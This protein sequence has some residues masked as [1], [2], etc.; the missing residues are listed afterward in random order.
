[1]KSDVD[2]RGW[3]K[4][5]S[6]GLSVTVFL[7]LHS[8]A[9]CQAEAGG[10]LGGD[11]LGGIITDQT[12]TR[13][14][15]DFYSGFSQAWQAPEGLDDVNLTVRERPSARWGSLVWV[16]YRNETVFRTFIF[17]GRSDPEALGSD[18]A[19]QVAERIARYRM[20]QLMFTDPDL[21]PGELWEGR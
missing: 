17:P 12:I 6:Q 14:G 9:D 19:R 1:M 20:E 16:E 11:G 3:L 8:V 15:R 2:V 10:V 5:C 18:A 4:R 13:F 7:L 21:A